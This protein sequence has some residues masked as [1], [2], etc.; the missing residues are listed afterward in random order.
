MP[1]RRIYSLSKVGVLVTLS[2]LLLVLGAQSQELG[3]SVVNGD[4]ADPQGAVVNGASVTVEN[5]ATGMQRANILGVSTTNYSGF[6]NSL[7][8]DS[9]DPLHSSAFGKPVSTARGIFGSGGLFNW[10]EN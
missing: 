1:L 9:N 2:L 7:V 4:V 10:E 5:K 3:T 8:P 6:F